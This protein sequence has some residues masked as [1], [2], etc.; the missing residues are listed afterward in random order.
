MY[1]TSPDDPANVV[2]KLCHKHSSEAVLLGEYGVD[3]NKVGTVDSSGG[4]CVNM[5]THVSTCIRSVTTESVYYNYAVATVC[6][7][8]FFLADS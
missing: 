1:E 4:T 8:I 6:T 7:Y 2:S 5:Y 3:G